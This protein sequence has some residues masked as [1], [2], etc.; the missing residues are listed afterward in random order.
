MTRAPR[1]IPP[2]GGYRQRP[3]GT[4]ITWIDERFIQDFHRYNIWPLRGRERDVMVDSAM[5]VLLSG[6]IVFDGPLTEDTPHAKA[7]AY[8]RSMQRRAAAGAD[9][10]QRTFPV[11]L[12]RAADR[13]LPRLAQG[14][15]RIEGV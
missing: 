7:D 10:A 5:G 2:K 8:I 12:R 11:G 9:R 15:A 3:V 1:R 6:D 14:H 4:G 13:D